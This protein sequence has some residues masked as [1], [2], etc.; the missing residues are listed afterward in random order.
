MKINVAT[1]AQYS[2]VETSCINGYYSYDN[3]NS[4]TDV[5]G[6]QALP[7]IQCLRKIQ[8]L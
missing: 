2:S 6:Y 3:I 1:A 4:D 5:I 7:K 8:I